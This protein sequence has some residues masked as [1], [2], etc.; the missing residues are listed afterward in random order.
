[1]RIIIVDSA[2]GHDTVPFMPDRCGPDTLRECHPSVAAETVRMVRLNKLRAASKRSEA[3]LV[4][5]EARPGIQPGDILESWRA[6]LSEHAELID[7]LSTM[8][9]P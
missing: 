1:M 5:L 7:Y 3:E 6:M 8:E 9:E 4:K 2:G